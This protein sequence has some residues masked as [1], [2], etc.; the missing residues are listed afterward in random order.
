MINRQFFHK[1]LVKTALRTGLA[2]YFSQMEMVRK[3]CSQ[4]ITCRERHTTINKRSLH[5]IARSLNEQKGES[6][7]RF[8]YH[9]DRATNRM[10]VMRLIWQSYC[11]IVGVTTDEL[12][13]GHSGMVG[14]MKSLCTGSVL[15]SG[16]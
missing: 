4:V 16:V 12:N 11:I 7:L 8:K 13:L 14:G 3:G 15:K 5:F 6:T 10:K 1:T 2:I 9:D